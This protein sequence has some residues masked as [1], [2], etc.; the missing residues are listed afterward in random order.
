MC[1]PN[2]PLNEQIVAQFPPPEEQPNNDVVIESDNTLESPQISDSVLEAADQVMSQVCGIIK[3]LSD[4]IEK[5]TQIKDLLRENGLNSA[6]NKFME[7]LKEMLLTNDLHSKYLQL[8]EEVL[9]NEQQI[10]SSINAFVNICDTDKET[11]SSRMDAIEYEINYRSEE[12]LIYSMNSYFDENNS[13]QFRSNLETIETEFAEFEA[14]QELL[15]NT[16][17]DYC[18]GMDSMI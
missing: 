1:Y 14:N 18:R 7:K 3:F 5:F 4:T 17:R 15:M 11:M 10:E 9:E 8:Y 13:L 16:F 2:W 12:N 6:I